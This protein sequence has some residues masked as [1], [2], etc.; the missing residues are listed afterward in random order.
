MARKYRN[1]AQPTTNLHYEVE[2]AQL[3]HMII[4]MVCNFDDN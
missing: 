4:D 1:S 3:D 2:N